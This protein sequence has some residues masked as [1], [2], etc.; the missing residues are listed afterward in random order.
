MFLDNNISIPFE[1][2]MIQKTVTISLFVVTDFKK[3]DADEWESDDSVGR[4]FPLSIS[5]I[6]FSEKKGRERNAQWLDILSDDSNAKVDVS[7]GKSFRFG[8]ESSITVKC[9]ETCYLRGMLVFSS[10]EKGIK[11]IIGVSEDKK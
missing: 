7:F 5:K 4:A 10:S 9:Q 8:T 6:S 3:I 2:N 1:L 11:G